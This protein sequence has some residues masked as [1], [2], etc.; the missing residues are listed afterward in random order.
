MS[1]VQRQIQAFYDGNCS[2]PALLTTYESEAYRDDPAWIDAIFDQPK[3]HE[4]DYSV[5]SHFRDPSTAVLDVGANYGYSVSSMCAA[6]CASSVLSVEAFPWYREHLDRVRARD[7]M[8]FDFRIAAVGDRDG[9]LR[10]VTPV[11]NGRI[12]SALSS[13]CE[14]TH[15]AYLHESIERALQARESS[16]QTLKFIVTGLTVTTLDGLVSAYDG[17]LSLRRIEAIKL[18]VEGLEG[19]VIAGAAWTIA[20]HRP[21][22][23]VEAGSRPEIVGTLRGQGYRYAVRKDGALLRLV[24]ESVWAVNPFFVHESRLDEYGRRG[25]LHPA[26]RA[27][28]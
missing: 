4:P 18:D 14:R 15:R 13:A 20:H 23:M 19:A 8:R 12:D 5:F 3:M 11:V 6:G 10:F 28:A 17:P 24:P 16:L 1:A 22:L 26:S 9:T 27:A 21:L 7:P 2:D 25:L